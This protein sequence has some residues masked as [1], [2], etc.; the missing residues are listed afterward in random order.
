[1]LRPYVFSKKLGVDQA[2]ADY[3][4]ARA[5]GPA[6]NY[7]PADLNRWGYW[8]LG[9]GQTDDALKVFEANV[10]LYPDDA[11]AYDSLGE[12]YLKAGKKELA[13]KNYQRSL[14]RNPQNDNAV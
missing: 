10:T 8:L 1:M 13:I 3:V 12:G 14:E 9:A 5:R 7:G 6:K 11:N 4:P 2:V